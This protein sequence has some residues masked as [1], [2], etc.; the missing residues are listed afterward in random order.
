M[1]RLL[2]VPCLSH[3]FDKRPAPFEHRVA[4]CELMVGC[5]AD[6]LVS[7]A[8][9]AIREP[10]KTLELVRYLIETNPG[11]SFRLVAGSDIYHERERWY[12]FDEV[13]RLAPLIYV[14]R[15]GVPPIP[16]DV[17]D[18]PPAVSSSEVRE[19]LERGEVPTDLVPRAVADYI[20]SN[21]L[22]GI[23]R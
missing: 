2:V 3:A 17:L 13:A 14:A 7:E 16:V 15:R 21:N 23:G 10:G 5:E 1:D 9:A 20:V 8:E 12:A 11:I 22:Y 19:S 6:M 18:A 4:M